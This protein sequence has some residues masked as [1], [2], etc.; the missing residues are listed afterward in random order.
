MY[1]TWNTATQPQYHIS[2]SSTSCSIFIFTCTFIAVF[3]IVSVCTWPFLFDFLQ[4]KCCG[5]KNYTDWTNTTYFSTNKTLPLSCCK[6]SSSPQCNGKL[7]EW[8]QFN[9][10]VNHTWANFALS[11]SLGV[12]RFC[13][14]LDC[15]MF[16]LTACSPAVW[17]LLSFSLRFFY[18]FFKMLLWQFLSLQNLPAGRQ[19]KRS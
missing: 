16:T 17:I 19:R 7:E 3:I 1:K 13:L 12:T 4:L 18:Y 2:L 15:M 14:S 5:V 10:E 8:Q 6:N 11:V 9:T